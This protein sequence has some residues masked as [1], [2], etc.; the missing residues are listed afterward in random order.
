DVVLFGDV[1]PRYFSDLQLE[2]IRDFVANRGGGFGMVAGPQWSPQAYQNTPIEAL[3]P[4]NIQRTQT[5][6]PVG[7]TQGWRPV[8][9]ADGRD[10][11][12]FRFFADRERNQRYLENEWPVLY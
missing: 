12:I 1:D 5:G 8:L 11:S 3:L 2:L 9:T 10:S 6:I 4:V 7:I